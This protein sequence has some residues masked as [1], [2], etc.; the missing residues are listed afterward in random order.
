MLIISK[1]YYINHI[2]HKDTFEGFLY[3]KP[4]W[5]LTT[6]RKNIDTS[7]TYDLIRSTILVI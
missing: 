7:S 2:I 3:C 1:F 6:H 4:N 5:E